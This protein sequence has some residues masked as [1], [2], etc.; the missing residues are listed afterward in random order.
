MNTENNKHLHRLDELSNW[1]VASD[2]P[3]VRGW[4]LTDKQ[5]KKVGE[6]KN[7]LVSKDAQKVRYLDVAVDQS[8]L[9][10]NYKPYGSGSANNLS[11]S[12]SISGREVAAADGRASEHTGSISTHEYLNADGENHLIVPIG[13]ARLDH[14]NHKVI[15]DDIPYDTY[16]R[17]KRV[18]E[19]AIVKRNY[20]TNVL[21]SYNRDKDESDEIPQ[22][23]TLYDRKEYRG[24][25]YQRHR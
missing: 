17:T 19:D 1:K 24:E 18:K 13:Y 25:I 22:D 3:D 23:D 8:I 14:D 2:D 12:D 15:T 11:A 20:E 7:L 6:V 5:G 21:H 10:L 4:T 9:D 16:A